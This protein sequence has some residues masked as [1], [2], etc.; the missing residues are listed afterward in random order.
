[1]LTYWCASN[2]FSLS[3]LGI[4]KIPA[5]KARY[6]I[7]KQIK[8]PKKEG[9]EPLPGFMDSFRAATAA[10][11]KPLPTAAPNPKFVPT[12]TVESLL[13]LDEVKKKKQANR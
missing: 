7:E 2:F 10:N 6:G 13:S 1:M 8:W 4:M 9:E 12:T 5:L 11:I 3:Q